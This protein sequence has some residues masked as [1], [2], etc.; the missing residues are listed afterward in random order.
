MRYALKMTSALQWVRW[1][2][3]TT[4]IKVR[5]LFYVSSR[6][7]L[8][9]IDVS[10]RA[11]RSPVLCVSLTQRKLCLIVLAS[12]WLARRRWAHDAA[13]AS[14]IDYIHIY[15]YIYMY[16]Y[17]CIYICMYTIHH[18]IQSWH[19]LNTPLRQCA[20]DDSYV[21]ICMFVYMYIC[22]YI[23]ICIYTKIYVCI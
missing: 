23:Y 11:E 10:C 14:S 2:G 9:L 18:N 13:R 3:F 22:I 12:W 16:V 19:I 7:V 17:I 21:H 8:Q 6:F 4:R 5:M 15:I 20:N 1:N